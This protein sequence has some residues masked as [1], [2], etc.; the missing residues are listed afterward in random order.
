[1]NSIGKILD[2]FQYDYEGPIS[3]RK[4]TGYQGKGISRTMFL[5]P[6]LADIPEQLFAVKISQSPNPAKAGKPV[7]RYFSYRF[8]ENEKYENMAPTGIT[9]ETPLADVKNMVVSKLS[10]IPSA[11]VSINV[12]LHGSKT[13]LACADGDWCIFNDDEGDLPYYVK[14]DA[15]IRVTLKGAESQGNEYLQSMLS[16]TASSSD[17]FQKIRTGKIWGKDEADG[18]ATP[19]AANGEMG[20][21]W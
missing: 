13:F 11:Q 6:K 15:V 19:A 14:P 12:T 21:V 4:G 9:L 5:S 20:P 3:I 7:F 16:T 1:M 10:N 17:V 2:G 18:A 8:N